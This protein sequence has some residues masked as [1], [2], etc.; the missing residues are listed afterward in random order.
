MVGALLA[1]GTS[2]QSKSASPWLVRVVLSCLLIFCTAVMIFEI[3]FLFGLWVFEPDWLLNHS[4][5]VS[6]V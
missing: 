5:L 6:L 1:A 3:L 4:Q 2:A